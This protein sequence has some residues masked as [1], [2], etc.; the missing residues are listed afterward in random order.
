LPQLVESA[1]DENLPDVDTVFDEVNHTCA[2]AFVGIGD[3]GAQELYSPEGLAES[4]SGLAPMPIASAHR[5]PSLPHRERRTEAAGTIGEPESQG[6]VLL[7]RVASLSRS[8]LQA[9]WTAAAAK[10]QPYEGLSRIDPTER[11]IVVGLRLAGLAAKLITDGGSLWDFPKWVN[12]LD[13]HLPGEWGQLNHSRWFA[14]KFGDCLLQSVH[15]LQVMHLHASL[16]ALRVPSDFARCIDGLTP[17]LGESLLIHIV[18]SLGADDRFPLKWTL[19]DVTPQGYEGT[20]AVRR[21]HGR[22]LPR[23]VLGFHGLI[24]TVDKL[25]STE[26]RCGLLAS[27]RKLRFAVNC[28]DGAVEGVFG[29]GV[30]DASAARSGLPPGKGWGALDGVH[31]VDKSGS[32]ADAKERGRA[33]LIRAFLDVLDGVR[34]NFGFG[35]GRTVA[36]S[37]AKKFNLPWRSPLAPHSSATRMVVYE[38]ERC[39]PNLF[40]NLRTIARSLLFREQEAI[41]NARRKAIA[42]GEN[43]GDDRGIRCKIV[44]G[45]RDLGRQMLDPEMLLFNVVRWEHRVACLLSYGKISQS[46]VISGFEKHEIQE[47]VAERMRLY[48]CSLRALAD[49]MHILIVLDRVVPRPCLRAFFRAIC[50]SIAGKAFPRLAAHTMEVIF[51]RTFQGLPMGLKWD[52]VHPF[53]EPGARPLDRHLDRDGRVRASRMRAI[54]VARGA[55]ERAI[56]WSIAE[57]KYFMQRVV[58]WEIHDPQQDRHESKASEEDA[59]LLDAE[60][61]AM[62][63]EAA[64]DGEGTFP[65][66]HREDF[67]DFPSDSATSPGPWRTR[68]SSRSSGSSSTSSST[69]SDGSDEE[70]PLERSAQS[71]PIR[72]HCQLLQGAFGAG[73]NFVVAKMGSS[74]V[75]ATL[76]QVRQRKCQDLR[77]GRSAA[78]VRKRI[79]ANAVHVFSAKW[80]LLDWSGPGEAAAIEDRRT[81]LRFLFDQFASLLWGI[82][83]A[84]CPYNTPPP[85]L[86][87]RITFEELWA[88][89]KPFHDLCRRVASVGSR[90]GTKPVRET[91]FL[92]V[93]YWDGRRAELKTLIVPSSKAKAN[94]WRKEQGVA[95]ER[96]F[97]KLAGWGEVEVLEKISVPRDHL[98]HFAVVQVKYEIVHSMGV[99]HMIRLWHRLFM[100]AFDVE[101]IDESVASVVRYIE[102]KHAVGKPLETANLIRATRLRAAGVRG[103][104]RDIGVLKHALS[105]YFAADP[106]GCNFFVSER[107]QSARLRAGFVGPSATVNHMRRRELEHSQDFQFRFLL[108]GAIG[109]GHAVKDLQ[110]FFRRSSAPA[111]IGAEAWSVTGK[112]V[113]LLSS[114]EVAGLSIPSLF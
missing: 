45:C 90:S 1:A 39:P 42:A 4:A 6:E 104:L 105:K 114:F 93:R 86:A 22:P 111:E 30:G 18:L 28:G 49:S 19:L 58:N 82:S 29:L 80:L 9:I 68:T 41:E 78:G 48:T 54:K 91:Q 79:L 94:S 51:N 44:R 88:Q 87:Q 43:V 13:S 25:H 75:L 69:S 24:R 85:E 102:K 71:C 20:S 53:A 95:A 64:E 106:D 10:P 21:E 84:A 7:A 113:Q 11:G 59:Q 76:A 99:W 109:A 101:A 62:A 83:D 77:E 61:N 2:T 46:L 40:I 107:T 3:V 12:L 33:G 5:S 60:A 112:H 57:R 14:E 96:A 56:A 100:H 32:L 34:K 15:E 70:T 47:D 63:E 17:Q 8:K 110:S 55:I 31:A 98:L 27:D 23:D 35:I 52:T 66:A 36:Q 108:E 38:S 72:D 65:L 81:S 73:G 67:V 26:D 103:D 92:K 74:V 89:Y 37:V 97:V 16:R 50:W